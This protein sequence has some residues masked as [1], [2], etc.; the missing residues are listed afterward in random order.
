MGTNASREVGINAPQRFMIDAGAANGWTANTGAMVTSRA[1]VAS[2]PQKD[3][4]NGVFIIAPPE[5][6]LISLS[7]AILGD[8]ADATPRTGTFS[9]RRWH[10]LVDGT[11][12]G[13]DAKPETFQWTSREL[14]QSA[15]ITITMSTAPV[16]N[17]GGTGAR[18]NAWRNVT[19]ANIASRQIR[20]AQ[21]SLGAGTNLGLQPNG[22]R[23]NAGLAGECIIDPLGAELI[24]VH[25]ARP[26]NAATA[27]LTVVA[28]GITD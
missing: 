16:S 8:P 3:M 19:A 28:T 5:G 9:V 23:F 11:D 20:W 12:V 2:E 17:I 6:K 4:A 10:R 22:V 26:N 13:N 18:A 7:F 24:E 21:C 15:T 27:F 14:L 1:D 25:A